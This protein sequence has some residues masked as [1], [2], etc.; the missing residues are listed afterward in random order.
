MLAHAHDIGAPPGHQGAAIVQLHGP[1]RRAGDGVHRL[2][3]RQPPARAI[4]CKGTFDQAARHI[5]RRKA[6][7]HARF[8]QV[9]GRHVTGIGTAA[10]QIGAAHDHAHAVGT[11]RLRRL[12]GDRKFG[13]GDAVAGSIADMLGGFVIMAGQRQALRV[14][15]IGHKAPVAGI[16]LGHALRAFSHARFNIGLAQALLAPHGEKP[17]G[18]AILALPRRVIHQ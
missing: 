13:Y 18:I 4:Q 16:I 15:D 9:A 3:D 8:D 10:N 6:D 14:R 5:I 1:R 12:G 7:V 11:R 17:A 2:L